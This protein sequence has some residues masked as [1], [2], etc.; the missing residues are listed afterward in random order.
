MRNDEVPT[1][2]ECHECGAVVLVDE[3]GEATEAV[4]DHYAEAH[5]LE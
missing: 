5:A 1:R 2:F 4:V 3:P